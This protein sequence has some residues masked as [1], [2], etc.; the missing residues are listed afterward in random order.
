MAETQESAE[1]AA[2]IRELAK[3]VDTLGNA[4]ISAAIEIAK[5]IRGERE[6]P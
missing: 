2:A 1:V 6:A 3:Q 5:A 4:V